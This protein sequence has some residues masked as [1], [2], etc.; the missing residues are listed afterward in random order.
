M[1]ELGNRKDR[2]GKRRPVPS[3]L[4][5]YLPWMSG[6]LLRPP[7]PL[8]GPLDADQAF[9]DYETDGCSLPIRCGNPKRLADLVQGKK[10]R[11]WHITEWSQ[12]IIRTGNLN[13]ADALFYPEE[14][15]GT[16]GLDEQEFQGVFGRPL[17][18]HL[19]ALLRGDQ[20]G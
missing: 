17:D 3:T 20:H 13:D 5:K 10:C 12:C 1:P 18:T 2:L 11:D 19:L 4:N 16:L 6:G 14:F 7:L 9:Y 15:L 8:E